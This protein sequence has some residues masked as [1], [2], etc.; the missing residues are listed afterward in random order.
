MENEVYEVIRVDENSYRIEEGT[1]RMFLFIGTKKALLVDSGYGNGNL[2]NVV[3]KLTSLPVMLV[4]THADG[5]HV[6]CNHLFDGAYMHPAEFDRYHQKLGKDIL[7]L[8]LWEGETIDLGGRCF[9]VILIPGHT[10]GSI[11]LLDKDN[12]IL[13][14]GDSVQGGAAYMFGPGRDMPAFIHSMKK[15]NRMKD[16]FDTI[17]PSHGGFPE[18][19]CFIEEVIDGAE[20]VLYGKA[21]GKTPHVD[22]PALLYQV[23]NV[24]FLYK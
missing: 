3:E 21:I 15:L 23:G 6:G 22:V 1:V 13:I 14:A 10:P 16:A 5:D 12:R 17:Y 9:Q 7:A 18:K 2:R 19:A 4:N 8:P 11:A 24:R 20:K